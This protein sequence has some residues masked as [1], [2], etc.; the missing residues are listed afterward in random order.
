MTD[1]DTD[2]TDV[3]APAEQHGKGGTEA[4][5]IK[6]LRA[7]R[8]EL[9]QQ[10]N[11]FQQ[12]LMQQQQA[13]KP[14]EAPEEPDFDYSQLDNE[15]FPDGKKLAKAFQTVNRKLAT[16]DKRLAEKDRKIN[17]LETAVQNKDFAHIVTPDNIKKYIETDEDNLDLVR[18]AENP[19]QKIYNLIKKSAAYQADTKVKAAPSQE[20]SKVDEK[21]S[22]PK[23]SSIGVRSDAITTAAQIS[24]S[25]MTREQRNTLWAES[26]GFAKNKR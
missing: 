21:G 7:Q 24:Q 14:V 12:Q 22:K 5:N 23:T 1:L 8:D 13:Q 4:D 19:G 15:D 20:Q 11:W 18:R 16:Y 17:V 25:K 10:N 26:Q 2:L 9:R 3:V 6:A